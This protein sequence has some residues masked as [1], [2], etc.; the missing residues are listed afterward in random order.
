[1]YAL[2]SGYGPSVTVPS[3]GHHAHLFVG[4]QPAAEH[5]DA[6]V[7]CLVHHRVRCLGHVGK[8]LLGKR[9]RPVIERDQ[10]PRHLTTPFSAACSGRISPCYR[11]SRIGD[12]QTTENSSVGP[13]PASRLRASSRHWRSRVLPGRGALAFRASTGVV[14]LSRIRRMK[15]VHA[16][17]VSAMRS[18]PRCGRTERNP[19]ERKDE[20][21]KP[22]TTALV[23][24][25]G[26]AP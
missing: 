1:M 9:H 22:A 14:S 20:P 3:S 13:D 8:V 26:A 12:R 17:R 4:M 18:A 7:L 23:S 5:P 21:M 25:D 24:V 19:C 11:H 16:G 10:I 2:L 6:G 15:S